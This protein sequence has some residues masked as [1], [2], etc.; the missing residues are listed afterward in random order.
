VLCDSVDGTVQHLQA[1]RVWGLSRATWPELHALLE[2]RHVRLGAYGDPAAI[3]F[4]VWRQLLATAAGHSRTPHAWR[5]CDPRFK[6]IAMASV[7]DVR[8]F[9]EAGLRG[10]RTFRIRRTVDDAIIAGA[11]FVCPA[12]DEA[13]T[14]RRARPASSVAGRARPRGRWPSSHTG[15]RAI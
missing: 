15:S 2:G 6:A 8:E 5:T 13:G 14:A 9:H 10:W 3:P 11:E 1:G 4:E 7:D 12:S